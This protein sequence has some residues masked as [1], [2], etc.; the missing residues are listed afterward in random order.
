MKA[1]FTD[2]EQLLSGKCPPTWPL[3]VASDIGAVRLWLTREARCNQAACAC[4]LAPLCGA[5]S[6]GGSRALQDVSEIAQLGHLSLSQ[7]KGPCWESQSEHMNILPWC[8]VG[9]GQ[10]N[11][12]LMSQ[13]ISP[14]VRRCYVSCWYLW[15]GKREPVGYCLPKRKQSTRPALPK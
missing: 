3:R 11:P 5:E 6:L 15:K 12:P 4:I 2:V 13:P 1:E 7:Q 14:S 10:I 8:S 9:R